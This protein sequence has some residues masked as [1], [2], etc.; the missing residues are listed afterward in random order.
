M[1]RIEPST[2]LGCSALTQ[3]A[4]PN[5][6]TSIGGYA[7][8][9]CSALAQ[10][11][12]GNNVTSIGNCAFL[13]CKALTQVTIPNSVTSIGNGAFSSSALTQVTI[14]NSVTS[15]GQASF[16]G[17]FRLTAINVESGNTAYYSENGV[18]FN[19]DQ[20]MLVQYS[21]GKTETTYIL[22]ER[23]KNIAG[24]AFSGCSA[25][26]QVTI[27]NSVTNIGGYAFENCSALRQVTIGHSV[28]SIGEHAFYNCSA[29]MQM[30][31][32]AVVPPVI[33]AYTFDGVS[34]DIPVYVP[35]ES[36]E[37]YR[38][39]DVWKEFNLQSMSTGLSTLSLPESLC[40]YGGVLHN[41]LGLFV[42]IYDMQGRRVYSGTDTTVSQ[43]V[44][45]Y[46]VRCAGS[47]GKVM[48]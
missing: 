21:A 25:L 16:L 48:F 41:P 28:A 15:I 47:S 32:Q 24:M 14:P 46:V 17:C 11:T 38:E 26:M 45:V 40:V 5:S 3:I 29:L 37:A 43:P 22:P 39:A 13:H 34:R 27:G 10:V 8:E 42:S 31:V 35:D 12:I 18:L 7:F 9:N 23:V 36:L 4:V 2:F 33:E 19:K 1:T 20:T 30:T 6:V 44:G